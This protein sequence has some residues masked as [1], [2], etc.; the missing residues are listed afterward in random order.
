MISQH[1]FT[2][3]FKIGSLV[4]GV[5]IE[6]EKAAYGIVHLARRGGH[7]NLCVDPPQVLKQIPCGRLRRRPIRSQLFDLAYEDDSKFIEGYLKLGHGSQRT[8]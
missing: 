8:I 4:H 5:Q 2:A 3:R 7:D 1:L 6:A